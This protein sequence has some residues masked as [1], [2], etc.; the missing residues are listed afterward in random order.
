M[1]PKRVEIVNDVLAIAWEDAH[2]SYFTLEALRRACPCAVC[3]GEA[4]VMVEFKPAPKQYSPQSFQLLGWQY[5]G[6]YALQ[7]HWAD[8]HASGI[9]SFDYLRQL[10]DCEQCQGQ[11][12]G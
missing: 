7:P 3:K 10:C 8:G 2:E 9:Y 11:R 1:K 6:G 12:A 5:V 4:N